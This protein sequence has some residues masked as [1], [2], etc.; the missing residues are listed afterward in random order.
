ML[1]LSISNGSHFKYP[2]NVIYKV[3]LKVILYYLNALKIINSKW[4][5]I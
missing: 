2:I 3:E 5:I 4:W 1:S